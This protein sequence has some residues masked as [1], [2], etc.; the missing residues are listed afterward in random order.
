MSTDKRKLKAVASL[1][2]QCVGV[3]T[4]LTPPLLAK[5]RAGVSI[6][7]YEDGLREL[8]CSYL[9]QDTHDCMAGSEGETRLCCHLYPARA[10]YVNAEHTILMDGKNSYVASDWSKFRPNSQN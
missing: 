9:N 7:V 6:T 1:T 5:E 10:R 4:R 3:S 2:F 8:G